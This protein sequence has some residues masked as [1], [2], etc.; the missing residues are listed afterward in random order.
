[1][2]Q[3]RD[4]HHRGTGQEEDENYHDCHWVFDSNLC[5]E[6]H[7]CALRPRVWSFLFFHRV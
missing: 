5:R 6:L 4:D 1:M 2:I 7:R 3:E